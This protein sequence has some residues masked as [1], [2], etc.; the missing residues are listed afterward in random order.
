MF[1]L[2]PFSCIK[3]VFVVSPQPDDVVNV[4]VDKVNGLLESFMGINDTELGKTPTHWHYTTPRLPTDHRILRSIMKTPHGSYY[5]YTLYKCKSKD[6]KWR[7][8]LQMKKNC[9]WTE[10]YLT[11]SCEHL[12]MQI[13]RM[14]PPWFIYSCMKYLENFKFWSWQGSFVSR[15]QSFIIFRAKRTLGLVDS[16][17]S[18]L[19]NEIGKLIRDVF[20]S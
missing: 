10:F 9:Y 8:A 7:N 1:L 13:R 5:C 4:A 12:S 20:Y 3:L 16:V 14:K 18:L 17:D 2:C 6:H 11:L 19:F 15:K